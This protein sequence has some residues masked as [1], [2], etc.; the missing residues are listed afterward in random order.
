VLGQETLATAFP[1]GFAE[2]TVVLTRP[3]S[4][5][6]VTTRIN[7]VEG[8]ASAKPDSSSYEW[9][10]IDVVLDSDRGSD[11]AATTIDRLRGELGDDALVGGPDAQDVDAADAAS[12]DRWIIPADPD[13]RGHVRDGDGRGL[14]HVHPPVRL[15]GH[16]P[17]RAAVLVHL[18]GGPGRRLQH[19]PD[20]PGPRGGGDQAGRDGDVVRPGRHGGVITSAGV[21]LAA[22]FAVLGVLP[23]VTLTQIGVIVGIGV[24]LDTLVVRSLLVPAP[25]TLLGER[26]WWPGSPARH[27]SS[28]R[29]SRRPERLDA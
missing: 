9:A 11:R 17:V 12:H 25:A 1:A 22:V 6:D 27:R 20:H 21:V 19:L 8:V 18:P 15:P 10:Q 13:G 24:L 4:M 7:D 5:A 28:G 26:F 14:V 23:L 3:D 2:P 29:S 16:G